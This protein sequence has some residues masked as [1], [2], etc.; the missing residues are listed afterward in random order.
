MEKRERY[1]SSDDDTDSDEEA[2]SGEGTRLRPLGGGGGGVQGS[3]EEEEEG[4]RS[5]RSSSYSRPSRKSL[6][7][8]GRHPAQLEQDDDEVFITDG[9]VSGPIGGGWRSWGAAR[10]SELALWAFFVLVGA[11]ILL[12]GTF[13][14]LHNA[15][16]ASRHPDLVYPHGRLFV[17]QTQALTLP[18]FVLANV[19]RPE[20]GRALAL[21]QV[22][23]QLVDEA[24]RAVPLEQVY[25][26]YMVLSA[27]ADDHDSTNSS[28][29]TH[30]EGRVL[31]ALGPEGSKESVR[32]PQ[33]YYI[34]SPEGE[35]WS[36]RCRLYSSWGQVAGANLTVAVLLNITYSPLATAIKEE[37][38]EHTVSDEEGLTLVIQDAT[39][40]QWSYDVEWSPSQAEQVILAYGFTQ[41]GALS[42]QLLEVS[43]SGAEE[44]E[45]QLMELQV[46]YEKSG[47]IAAM[48]RQYP[49]SLVLRPGAKL[50]IRSSFANRPFGRVF[51][52]W[53][54]YLHAR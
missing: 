34:H 40:A 15:T 4:R 32:L 25:R 45:S 42:S 2:N 6:D 8:G 22:R 3:E 41:I 31:V 10:K 30:G 7:G 11:L 54:L 52:Y 38:Q 14:V 44:S 12:A 18:E 26:S 1:H 36:L 39:S 21:H 51:F 33:G 20:P 19:S 53:Q 16:R 27:S 49:T 5:R 28:S 43:T 37:M 23:L 29:S 46:T 47:L 9:A 35:R 48:D 50:R 17:Y 24:G 13:L